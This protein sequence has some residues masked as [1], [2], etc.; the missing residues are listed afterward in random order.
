MK[1]PRKRIGDILVES[2]VITPQQLQDALR[3]QQETR[4]RLGRILVEMRVATEA[5]IAQALA[6]QLGL[7][8]VSLTATRVDP[9]LLRLIPESLARKR[10]VVPVALEGDSLVVALADPLDVFALDDVGIAAR[11]PVKAVV[12]L[13]S[14]IAAAIDRWYGMGAAA[15]AALDGA[16]APAEAEPAADEA[17]D[18]PIVRLV[19][20][21]LTQ[22]V[23]DR[24]SDVHIEPEPEEVRVR[25]RVDGVLQTVMKVPKGVHPALLSRLKVLA[26]LNIA[27]RRA[28]QDGAFQ[29]SV[30]GRE[31][32]VRLATIPTVL[33]ERASLRLLDKSR[34]LRSLA[35]L[36]MD[37][38]VRRRYEALARQPYGIILVSG[39]TG[40][41]KTTTLVSTLAL[42]NAADK[43]II[44][45]E[46]PVEYQLPGVSHIQVN[47]RAGLTFATGLRS[48]VRHDPDVIMIGE[49]RDVETADIA[50]H[51]ALTGHLVL[52]TIHTNDA[53]S[54]LARLVDMGIETFLIASAVNGVA[55][56]RLVR[57]LCPHCRRPI[58]PPPEIL[59]WLRSALG[60]EL[61]APS[62]HQAAGCARCRQT[63]YQGRTGIFEVLVMTDAVRNLVLARA[64]AADI[65]EAARAERMRS[66]R[67]DG[68]LKALR[69][70][71][72]V[73][74][75]LRVT[76]VEEPTL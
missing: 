33:G 15:Q 40:S 68:L 52:T 35:E 45:I 76:R 54:A 61:P 36:G 22:A 51:A 70:M 50:I 11:R 38:A 30:D 7:P 27:E 65:A 28:P 58:D 48:I 37:E 56:Q 43:N 4:D 14:D 24:A 47:P 34:G 73:E 46:D 19:N 67:A 12:A 66:M 44:T 9:A 75:V 71:T 32:D 18:A 62:F 6:R 31:I 26:R 64:S 2:G 25:F 53:A 17:E 49:I 59:V 1:S 63:G 55:S 69:G 57:T 42:I 72:T 23:K 10:R 3:R 21:L 29:W 60:D 8:L 16:A 74:E 20:M 41:G 5:Q 39:P 13:E